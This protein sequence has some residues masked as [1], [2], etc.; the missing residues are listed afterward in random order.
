MHNEAPASTTYSL[1]SPNGF[2][3]L[4]TLRGN[5]E[6]ELL[7]IM[8]NAE[9]Y[10][11]DNG[12]TPNFKRSSYP[13]KKP[14]EKKYRAAPCPKCGG[15]VLIK[16][17]T[18]KDGTKKTLEECENRKWDWQTKKNIGTCDYQ[19]WIED[20][21]T[22]EYATDKPTA[23][24]EKVLKAKGLWTDSLTQSEANELLVEARG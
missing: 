8:T 12:F 1:I 7:E 14:V 18:L 13:A 22:R 19:L 6:A 5:S 17:V 9:G 24:Q 20:T 23:G 4:F 3:M 10:L 15:R 2:P 21:P 11:K 16:E